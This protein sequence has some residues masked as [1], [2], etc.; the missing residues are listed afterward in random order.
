MLV[1]LSLAAQVVK[2]HQKHN[3]KPRNRQN[4]RRKFQRSHQD[5]FHSKA[6]KAAI[7][8]PGY[9]GLWHQLLIR[10]QFD[11]ATA[12]RLVT[13]CQRKNPSKSDRWCIE[14]VIWD[15]ERDRRR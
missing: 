11:V 4:L 6:A 7:T 5:S 9:A 2:A 12:E 8:N 15:L 13:D 14:K 10:V 3:P 1:A